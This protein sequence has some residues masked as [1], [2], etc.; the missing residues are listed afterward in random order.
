MH[1][2]PCGRLGCRAPILSD[3]QGVVPAAAQANDRNGGQ[4]AEVGRPGM[5][6]AQ[7]YK[8]VPTAERSLAEPEPS[9]VTGLHRL[10][11]CAYFDVHVRL[12]LRCAGK[13]RSTVRDV[14]LTCKHK[15]G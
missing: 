13:S 5:G 2:L 8:P 3:D 15:R 11:R 1:G 14:T 4:L 6:R 9:P 7:P 10:P 12:A